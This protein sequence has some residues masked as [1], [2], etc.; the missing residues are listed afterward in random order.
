MVV[1]SEGSFL[2]LELFTLVSSV[3]IGIGAI[4]ASYYEISRRRHKLPSW[5]ALD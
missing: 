5:D 2:L 1:N 4:D 3:V